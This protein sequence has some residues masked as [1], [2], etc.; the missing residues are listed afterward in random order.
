MYLVSLLLT[1]R[2][3]AICRVLQTVVYNLQGGNRHCKHNFTCKYI[4]LNKL[5]QYL[6]AKLE[7][8]YYLCSVK[9]EKS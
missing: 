6:T 1:N 5:I 2:K 4:F 9:K 3:T 8:N 7:N